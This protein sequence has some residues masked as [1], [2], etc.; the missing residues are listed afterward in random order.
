M[1]DY[2]QEVVKLAREYHEIT[3]KEA[4]AGVENRSSR[5]KLWMFD[6]GNLHSGAEALGY[7]RERLAA[8]QARQPEPCIARPGEPCMHMPEHTAQ[9]TWAA[10]GSREAA[11]S[12]KPAQSRLHPVHAQHIAEILRLSTEF[13]TLGAESPFREYNGY[14]QFA[15]AMMPS[16]P[17]ALA[18]MRGLLAQ[19]QRERGVSVP[20]PAV[21]VRHDGKTEARFPGEDTARNA[22][23]AWTYILK[24][25][26]QSVEWAVRYEGWSIVEIAPPDGTGTVQAAS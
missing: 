25:Q 17:D 7:M 13:G 6:T 15:D 8:A 4:F 1:I 5:I 22:N 20:G 26:A 9:R 24:H 18:H 21:E 2:G 16:A 3:G 11:G 10:Y 14:Y 23:D 19:A 12:G